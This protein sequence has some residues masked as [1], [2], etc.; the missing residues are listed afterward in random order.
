[1]M[2][3]KPIRQ[4]LQAGRSLPVEVQT[5]QEDEEGVE[6]L[7]VWVWTDVVHFANELQ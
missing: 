4:M 3:A 7:I 2:A 1:M 6:D 5:E